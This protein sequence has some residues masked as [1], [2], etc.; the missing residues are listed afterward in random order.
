MEEDK[1]NR[2]I[3]EVELKTLVKLSV[4]ELEFENDYLQSEYLYSIY[5]DTG[6][7][8]FY[9]MEQVPGEAVVAYMKGIITGFEY[10]LDRQ[11]KTICQN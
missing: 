1:I 10:S 6:D 4:E 9:I 8:R 5:L 7:I 11:F 2:L 3:D